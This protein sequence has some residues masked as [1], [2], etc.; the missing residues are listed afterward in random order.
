MPKGSFYR[1][2]TSCS[3]TPNLVPKTPTPQVLT[4]FPEPNR[5]PTR[6][7]AGATV[8]DINALYTTMAV[9]VTLPRLDTTGCVPSL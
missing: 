7:E 1:T 5:I 4:P 2:V 3:I 6:V 8:R 9:T